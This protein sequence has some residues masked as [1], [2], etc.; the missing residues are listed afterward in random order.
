MNNETGHK[1]IKQLIVI[2][3]ILFALT[4]A[5]G[6]GILNSVYKK[7]YRS[8]VDSLNASAVKH[9][10]V[11]QISNNFNDIVATRDKDVFIIYGDCS[12]D[13]SYVI[14]KNEI[15]KNNTLLFGK[16]YKKPSLY[17]AIKF[18]NGEI[19]EV[20]SSTFPLEQ[21]NLCEYSLHEQ[22]KTY[23]FLKK[24]KDTKVIG[25]YNRYS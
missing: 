14:Y 25:Y 8:Y 18:V 4:I 6:L 10:K 9:Y 17:W 7:Q 19:K 21:E 3:L 24:F 12:K 5:L 23:R 22:L 13:G 20:W 11:F 15:I 16:E 1:K 2:F